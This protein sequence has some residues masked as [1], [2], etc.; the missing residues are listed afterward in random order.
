MRLLFLLFFPCFAQA[1]TTQLS[2][3]SNRYAAVLAIDTCNGR[4]EVSDTS[5]FR[6]GENIL[7]IQMQGAVISGNNN[8]SFGEITNLG[9]AGQFERVTVDSVTPGTL[10]SGTG[11]RTNMT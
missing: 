1:Q 3:I 8:A 2:G 6:R 7:L 4:I 10:F 5:G 11:C 9:A